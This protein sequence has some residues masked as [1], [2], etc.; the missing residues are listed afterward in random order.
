M[1][2]PGARHRR[3][4]RSYIQQLTQETGERGEGIISCKHCVTPAML[5]LN[6]KNDT[7]TNYEFSKFSL[8]W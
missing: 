2:M 3:R 7:H 4:R 1:Q 6:G 8:Q 5:S